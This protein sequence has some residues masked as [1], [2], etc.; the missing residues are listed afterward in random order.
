M[1]DASNLSLGGTA[2]D[3]TVVVNDRWRSLGREVSAGFNLA[4]C[5]VD[6]LCADIGDPTA[7][8]CVLEIN[9]APGLDHY[10]AVG[11][12]QHDLVRSLY[13]RV[14]DVPPPA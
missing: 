9:A 2:E 3:V 1:Q 4:Y 8:Y 11:P 12:A 6:L 13:A 14:L 5:G 7:A 10:A